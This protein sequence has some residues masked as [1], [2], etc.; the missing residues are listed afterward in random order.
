MIKEEI[1]LKQQS[2]IIPNKLHGKLKIH[3]AKLGM[4]IR[5]WTIKVISDA[6]KKGK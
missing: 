6:I 5:A 3:C 4:K 2:V 1:P